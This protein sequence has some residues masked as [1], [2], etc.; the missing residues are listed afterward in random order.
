MGQR[1]TPEAR[2]RIRRHRDVREVTREHVILD[3]GTVL[4]PAEFV[5]EE[6]PTRFIFKLL[7]C[8]CFF[9]RHSPGLHVLVV[10]STQVFGTGAERYRYTV[11]PICPR[12]NWALEEVVA[13]QQ[14]Q[15]HTR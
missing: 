9:T 1:L 15:V 12:G 7:Q 5:V 11:P 3:N 4:D 2:A 10:G 8:P 13:G 6:R 14:V